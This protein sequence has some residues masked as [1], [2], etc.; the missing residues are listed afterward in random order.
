M[1]EAEKKAVSEIEEKIKRLHSRILFIQADPNSD[2]MN[3]FDHIANNI[4]ARATIAKDEHVKRGYQS[5][6]MIAASRNAVN[7]LNAY[8]SL[9][10]A[11]YA[12]FKKGEVSLEKGYFHEL[13]LDSEP[14]QYVWEAKKRLEEMW[15]A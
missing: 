7:A 13:K 6:D 14:E 5:D 4:L 2:G 8:L 12:G 15:D 1:L 9:I 3:H 11:D 10:F